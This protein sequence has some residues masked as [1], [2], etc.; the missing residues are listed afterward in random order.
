[1]EEANSAHRSAPPTPPPAPPPAQNPV[2]PSGVYTPTKKKRKF[3]D[4]EFQASKYCKIRSILKG[5]RPSI[6]DVLRAPDYHI[7]KCADTIRKDLRLIMELSKQLRA[8][9]VSLGKMR[10]FETVEDIPDRRQEEKITEKP[11]VE[12]PPLEEKVPVVEQTVLKKEV[13]SESHLIGGSPDAWNFITYPGSDPVYYG[14]LKASVAA[15]REPV[16]S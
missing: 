4:A 15:T 16:Q 5:L 3:D 11:A 14:K 8:E 2:P 10:R 6:I 1:M 9:T 7:G 12:K 13:A